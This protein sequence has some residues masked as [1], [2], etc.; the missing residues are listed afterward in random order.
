MREIVLPRLTETMEEATIVAWAVRDGATVARGDPLVEIETDKA[1]TTLEAE[2]GG[3]VQIVAPA[4]ETVAVG[5]PIARLREPADPAEPSPAESLCTAPALREG[6]NG[7]AADEPETIRAT[8]VARRQARDHGIDL[9]QVKGTGRGGRIRQEDVERVLTSRQSVPALATVPTVQAPVEL[10]APGDG[11]E[12]RPTGKGE[13]KLER[14]SEMQ[15]TIA[16]RMAAAKATVPDFSVTVD[17]ELEPLLELRDVLRREASR[18]PSVNDF[19]VKASALALREHPRVNGCFKDGGFVLHSR[20]NIGIA[21]ATDH[22]LLV[23]T[24]FDADTK[25]VAEIAR[26]ARTLASR[27]RDRT[28][29]PPELGGGTF[30]ISN[31]GMFAVRRFTPIVNP[32]QAAILG[33]GAAQP[34]CVPGGDG[35]PRWA[36]FCELTLVSDHQIIYGVDAARFAGR[37]VELLEHPIGLLAGLETVR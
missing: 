8:P 15:K 31:L 4:G 13:T 26:E 36:R 7:R 25:P 22:G 12:A 23:P 17:A 34:R 10:P 27:A 35:Q 14:L 5:A 28:I 11:A 32:G 6:S 21:V 30:T 9:R 33:V 37:I 19:I 1:T 20:I 29:T 18:P 24:I 3:E 16:R 2:A